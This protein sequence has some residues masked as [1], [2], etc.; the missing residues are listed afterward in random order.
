MRAALRGSLTLPNLL[1]ASRFVLA[2]VFVALYVSGETVRALAA[3]A[4]AAA[5]DVLD[6]LVARALDQRSR[7]GAWMD[8]IADKFLAA[9]ALFALAARDRVP[10]WL[11]WIVVGRDLAQLAGAAALRGLRR[12][13]PVAPTRVGKYATFL[14]AA[15]VLAALAAEF[16]GVAPEVGAAYVAALALL[17]AECVAVSF[18]QYF[19]HFVR[20]AKAPR[21][22][23]P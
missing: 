14:L 6:G 9:C 7:L 18:A 11:P 8:P 15:T 17:A 3:F 10:G 20:T 16:S 5:T 4:A 13:V 21:W 2:P 23:E 22:R 12:S 19:L 1:T